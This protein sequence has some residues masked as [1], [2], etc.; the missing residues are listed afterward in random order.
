MRVQFVPEKAELSLLNPK[1]LIV[2]ENS[3]ERVVIRAPGK[4][5]SEREKD[6]FIRY[7]AAEGFISDEFEHFRK[8][9]WNGTSITWAVEQSRVK[10]ESIRLRRADRFMIQLFI[11][12]SVLWLALMTFAVLHS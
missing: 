1:N 8:S 4:N 11:S 5:F 3:E 6:C 2:V 12:A 7:L 9:G 10:C